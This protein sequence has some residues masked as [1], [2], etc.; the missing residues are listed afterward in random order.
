M[1]SPHPVRG[2]RGSLIRRLGVAFVAVFALLGSAPRAGAEPSPPPSSSASEAAPTPY[3]TTAH[4]RFFGDDA[5][6]NTLDKLAD[7]AEE[8]FARL[9]AQIDACNRVTRPIDIW[10][11]EDAER[12]AAGFPEKNPMA[13]WAAGVTFLAEQRIVLR[14]H[15]T[16][17]F[18]LM[19]TFEHEVAHVLAHT[20]APAI[21]DD[22]APGASGA[23][24]AEHAHV[25][26]RALPRWFAEGLAVWQAGE[27]LVQRLETALKAASSGKLLTFDELA[28]RFPNQGSNVEI[29]YAQSAIF[30]RRLVLASGPIA[31]IE[32]LRDTSKGVDFDEA[33]VKHFGAPPGDLFGR[34]SDDLEKSSNPFVFLS[35][36]NFLW[37]LT[38]VLFLAVAWWR[39][40]DRK[41]Q[42][43]KIADSEDARI[44]AEDLAL[45]EHR[46]RAA[47]MLEAEPEHV[48]VSLNDDPDGPIDP[49]GPDARPDPRLLN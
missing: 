35:D 20:Y 26:W 39:L 33:F 48:A 44:Q 37:G 21:R 47:A 29:A 14:A 34:L 38:T 17:V 4:F 25:H 3:R 31:V 40:R 9:C 45:Y 1:A 8:R 32:V 7:T 28:R 13:E 18:S 24:G 16:G 43:A 46:Q 36:G 10:V 22:P 11:A 19:E 2:P 12:F 30:V 5:V 23:E 6:E 42:M 15:G 27:G 49:D 41:R